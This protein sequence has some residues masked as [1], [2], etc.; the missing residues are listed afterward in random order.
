MS[1]LLKKIIATVGENGTDSEPSVWI[2]SGLPSLNKILSGDFHK[3]FAS[4]RMYSIAGDPSTGKTLLATKAMISAQKMGGIAIFI[5][6]EKSFSKKF[7]ENFGL[8]LEMPHFIYY[9]PDYFEQGTDAARDICLSVRESGEIDDDAPII[10]VLD[11]LASAVPMEVWEKALSG[12]KTNMRDKLAMAQSASL[13]LPVLNNLANKYN[14]T[15]II[16]NQ[17]RESPNQM[18]GNPKYEPGGKTLAYQASTRL[19]LSRK[20]VIDGKGLAKGIKS[21]TIRCETVK[22]KL[23]PAFQVA[24]WDLQFGD[25]GVITLDTELNT[26]QYARHTGAL[27]SS[28]AY[29]VWTDGKKYHMGPLANKIREESLQD[30]LISL[31]TGDEDGN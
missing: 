30:E 10:V 24:E 13:S 8:N 1:D 25:G 28:G 18:F 26:L 15:P 6:F 7:A 9:A 27:E 16:L 19:H 14:F 23:S 22:N 31:L 11:S 20:N 5:D 3:G 29:T 12:D 21:Q 2:D 4:G 17:L